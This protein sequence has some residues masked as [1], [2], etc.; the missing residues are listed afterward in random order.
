MKNK[1]RF[2]EYFLNRQAYGIIMGSDM[3]PNPWISYFPKIKGNPRYTYFIKQKIY[4]DDTNDI[5]YTPAQ[6]VRY[7]KRIEALISFW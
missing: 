6:F 4:V 1:H 3:D 5:T 7:I 2:I